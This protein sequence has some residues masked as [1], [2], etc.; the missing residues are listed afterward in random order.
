[1][2]GLLPTGNRGQPEIPAPPAG[3]EPKQVAMAAA[4]LLFALLL[5]R[6]GRHSGDEG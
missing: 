4:A 6:K 2:T 5:I 1:V 3:I